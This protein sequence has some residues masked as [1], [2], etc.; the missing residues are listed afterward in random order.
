ME[1]LLKQKHSLGHQKTGTTIFIRDSRY[2]SLPINLK[3]YLKNN[4]IPFN[5]NIWIWG[6]KFTFI[7]K[8]TKT[9][10]FYANKAGN[11]FVVPRQASLN[12]NLYIDDKKIHEPTFALKKGHHDINYSGSL[13]GFHIIWLPKNEKPFTPIESTNGDFA[14]IL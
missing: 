2:D 12:G 5:N 9:E 4:F 13:A 14:P 8:P 11:Y 1:R 7:Q 3:L 10:Q 6:K